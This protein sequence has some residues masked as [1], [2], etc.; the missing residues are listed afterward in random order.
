MAGGVEQCMATSRNSGK[1]IDADKNRV[2]MSEKS[3]VFSS[4][5]SSL[6]V[7]GTDTRL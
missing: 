5:V 2:P 3:L 1:G 6:S 7:S 4:M